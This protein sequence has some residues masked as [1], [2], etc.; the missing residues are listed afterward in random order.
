[1]TRGS[2]FW[3]R[4]WWLGAVWSWRRGW[5]LGAVD[6]EEEADGFE[7][8]LIYIILWWA[9]K[10]KK[11]RHFSPYTVW[12]VIS[13]DGQCQNVPLSITDMFV[14]NH[15]ENVSLF[16]HKIVCDSTRT[17]FSVIYHK[18]FCYYC[19]V[20]RHV[21]WLIE[22]KDGCWVG[23]RYNSDVWSKGKSVQILPGLIFINIFLLVSYLKENFYFV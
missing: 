23:S 16:N 10:T 9:F 12:K 22:E 17:F 5:W 18:R 20:C 3:R 8:S 6:F 21:Q 1:M 4:G 19:D 13:S 7:C 15:K 2:R 14:I 11:R